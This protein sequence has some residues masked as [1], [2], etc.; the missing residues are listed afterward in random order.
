M[1]YELTGNLYQKFETQKISEKFSKREFVVEKKDSAGSFEFIDHVKFQLTND[2][3]NLIDKF[4]PGE[5]LKVSFNIKGRKWEKDGK[6]AYFTN[7]EAW[8][9]ESAVNEGA[10]PNMP[11]PP[12]DEPPMPTEE[13]DLPF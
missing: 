3:C 1:S 11:P 2:K 6:I 5:E 12:M 7:L 10:A 13:T 9:I 8:R 4:N